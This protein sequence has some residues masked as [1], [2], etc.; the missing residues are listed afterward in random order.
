EDGLLPPWAEVDLRQAIPFALLR[1]QFVAELRPLP[2]AVYEEPLPVFAAW[3]DAPCG[4]LRF[5]DTPVYVPALEHARALGWPWLELP[6][7]TPTRLVEVTGGPFITAVAWAP[8]GSQIAYTRFSFA[9]GDSVGGADLHLVTL[10]GDDHVLLARDDPRT[11]LGAPAWEPDGSALLFDVS[12]LSPGAAGG[13]SRHI[14]RVKPDGS[15][16]TT[17]LDDAYAPSLSADGR[18]LAYLRQ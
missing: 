9:E 8:D 13:A 14:D 15:G 2:L 11:L 1:R 3:P 4:Y 10:R 18:W 7:G 5:T 17:E 16:R 12:Q 6:G